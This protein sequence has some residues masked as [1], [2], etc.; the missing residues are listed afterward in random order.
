MKVK[1]I[2]F[3]DAPLPVMVWIYGGAL[4]TPRNI[5][6]TRLPPKGHSMGRDLAKI[7]LSCCLTI[8]LSRLPPSAFPV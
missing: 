3:Q 7:V 6:P 5:P 8:L 2:V 4:E 1:E